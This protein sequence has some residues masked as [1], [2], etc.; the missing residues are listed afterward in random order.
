MKTVTMGKIM[1]SAKIESLAD[2]FDAQMGRI[3]KDQV[4]RVEVINA[5]V[6]R[7]FFEFLMPFCLIDQLGLEAVTTRTVRTI[8]GEMPVIEPS[9]SQCHHW[10][11]SARSD[12]LG[13]RHERT[14]SDWQS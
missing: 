13:G 9:A 10:P 3:A 7:R 6:D 5:M 12:G 4:R 2:C 14:A 1:V 11:D 8:T